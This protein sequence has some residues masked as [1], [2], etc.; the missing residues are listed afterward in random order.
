MFIVYDI[1]KNI[2]FYLFD[3]DLAKYQS[4]LIYKKVIKRKKKIYLKVI[5]I[6]NLKDQSY[7]CVFY[8]SS[9][10]KPSKHKERISAQARYT[11]NASL[12]Y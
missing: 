8:Q 7:L 12:I 1:R 3:N 9:G 2:Y 11:P 10:R 5:E 4:S 6:K